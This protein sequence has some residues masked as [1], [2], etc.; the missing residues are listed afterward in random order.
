MLAFIFILSI[1][2]DERVIE[3]VFD[4]ILL[5]L[6]ILLQLICLFLLLSYIYCHFITFL[7]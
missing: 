3:E 6:L 7:L 4:A 2:S 5:L 1:S